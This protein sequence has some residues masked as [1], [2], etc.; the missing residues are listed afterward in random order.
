[1]TWDGLVY[2]LEIYWPFLASA[3]VVGLLTG[4]LNFSPPKP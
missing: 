1:V 4:W 3:G 2:L